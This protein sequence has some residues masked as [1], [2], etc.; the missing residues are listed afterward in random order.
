MRST[1]EN[2]DAI[3]LFMRVTQHN[4][5][6]EK[7]PTTTLLPG[8]GYPSALHFLF[9]YASLEIYTWL[10]DTVQTLSIAM[11]LWTNDA[12]GLR[13]ASE[14]MNRRSNRYRHHVAPY[15]IASKVK[16]TS[17]Y[18]NEVNFENAILLRIRTSFHFLYQGF[19]IRYSKS[20]I[21]NAAVLC[22]RVCKHPCDLI[23]SLR[24]V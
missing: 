9:R 1:G 5:G 24:I 20:H 21:G 6:D 12:S 3:V 18:L 7:K 4:N 2:I 10:C 14:H 22:C 16:V 13:V 23:R 8:V 11:N 15:I 17:K 19:P